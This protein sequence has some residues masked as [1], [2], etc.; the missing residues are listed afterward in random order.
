MTEQQKDQLLY[1]IS[2]LSVS[3]FFYGFECGADKFSQIDHDKLYRHDLDQLL[4]FV[5][6]IYEGDPHETT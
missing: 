6:L 5:N 4:S 1:Y 2:S 3:S